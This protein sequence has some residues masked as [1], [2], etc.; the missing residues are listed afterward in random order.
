MTKIDRYVLKQFALTAFYA[1]FAFVIIFVAIN[2]MENLD[3]FLDKHASLG[4]IATY[5]LHFI[6]EIIKLVLPVAML[7]S[8]LFTT[9]RLTSSNEI[10]ALKSS[11]M[12]LYR[13]MLPI[14][15]FSLF[16][17]G[18]GVYF[19]GWVVPSANQKKL[20]IARAYFQKDIE[21][22]AKNNIFIEDSPTRILSISIFDDHRNIAQQVSIQD[23]DE[24]DPTIVVGRYDA[25]QMQWNPATSTW[26]LVNG[27][28]RRFIGGTEQLRHFT[29]LEIGKLNFLPEDI[30]KKQQKPEEMNYSDLREF[31]ASQQRAGHDVARWLVDLYAKVSFPFAS[32]VV[33]LFGIPFSSIKRR[34]GPGVEFGAAAAVTFLYLVFMQVSQAFGYNGDLDPLLTAWLANVLFLIAAVYNL[35]RVQK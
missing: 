31:I 27:I 29:K 10:T 1:L 12:S 23:F 6:P 9:G 4:I 18:A 17:S 33:V 25:Q 11:G 30:R 13:F 35:W 20:Q 16:V 2:M 21:Y 14:V 5:Y 15:V 26:T 34:S 22:V 8:A 7:L 28:E 3:D 32:V 19:T 24:H